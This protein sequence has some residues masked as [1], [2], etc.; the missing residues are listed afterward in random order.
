MKR[1]DNL[2]ERKCSI[3]GRPYTPRIGMPAMSITVGEVCEENGE[4]GVGGSGAMFP[5]PSC[6]YRILLL[7][8]KL[9]REGDHA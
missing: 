5:C 8:D 4:T 3:C 1:G 7:C 6:S 9:N 2:E